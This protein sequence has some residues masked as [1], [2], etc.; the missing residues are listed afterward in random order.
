[1]P[2]RID[3]GPSGDGWMLKS[4]ALPQAAFFQSGRQAEEQALALGSRLARRGC[5]AELIITVRDGY[6][7]GRRSFRE[8]SAAC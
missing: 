6:V 5:E 3:L 8:A 4:E 2:I 1:M 7:A